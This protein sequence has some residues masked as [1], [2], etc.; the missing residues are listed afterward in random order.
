MSILIKRLMP[1]IFFVVAIVNICN[2]EI[3]PPDI[4]FGTVTSGS[5]VQPEITIL[6]TSNDIWQIGD[7]GNT[8]QVSDPFRIFAS[9]CANTILQ[10]GSQCSFMVLFSPVSEGV[11]SDSFNVEFANSMLSYE[12]SLTGVGGPAIDEPDIQ[13]S[14]SSVNFGLVDVLDSNIAAPYSFPQIIENRGNLDL[15]I[16]SIGISGKDAAEISVSGGCIGLLTLIP[17]GSCL[18]SIDFKPLV[19]GDKGAEISIMT[20]DPDEDPFIIPVRGAATG[21]DDGVPQA[22]EDAGPNNG[23][24]NNDDILDSKQ[25]NV[26]TLI[27]SYGNYVTY[28]TDNRYRFSNM[29]VLQQTEVSADFVIGSGIFDFTTEG[30]ALGQLLEVGVI[31]PAGMKP[32]AYYMYGPTANNPVA[33]WFEFD[34]DGE[35]GAFILGDVTFTTSLGTRFTRSV[36]KLI[37]KDGGRGDA[38]LSENGVITVTSAMSITQSSDDSSGSMNFVYMVFILLLV[39]LPRRADYS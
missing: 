22:I 32:R 12:V 38:D 19:P 1:S 23:D 9:S 35:T 27:D 2:A 39:V 25:S 28:L 18:F 14:F 21:E 8:S 20:N 17:G 3:V 5:G 24:G 26:A 29:S 31:L 4:D 16:S 33:H 15:V 30:V 7:I 6:N 36:L 13:V 34:S 37:I 11:Y 10:P